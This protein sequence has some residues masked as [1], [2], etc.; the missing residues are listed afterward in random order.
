MH[1]T[2]HA[3]A[4]VVG[5]PP[6]DS[7]ELGA[8]SPPGGGGYEAMAGRGLAMR[9]YRM[10][11]MPCRAGSGQRCARNLSVGISLDSASDSMGVGS[12]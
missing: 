12:L 10:S 1:S 7:R 4:Q 8:C 2:G 9:K 3:E 11:V 5:D 6:L